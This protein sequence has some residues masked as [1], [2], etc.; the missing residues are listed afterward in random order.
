ML[1]SI[2]KK[3][4]YVLTG[5][6]KPHLALSFQVDN[7]LQENMT[8]VKWHNLYKATDLTKQGITY[9]G[10]KICNKSIDKAELLDSLIME[11]PSC[12]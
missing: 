8:A 5:K 2:N 3:L 11:I 12:D 4:A 7:N 9:I 6:A 1:N 10:V